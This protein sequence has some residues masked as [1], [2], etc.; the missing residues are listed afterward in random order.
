M[1]SRSNSLITRFSP[2][3]RASRSNQ[4]VQSPV[5]LLWC[6]LTCPLT[7]ATGDPT[8][9][10]VHYQCF[11]SVGTG[12]GPPSVVLLGPL[13][14]LCS[15]VSGGICSNSTFGCKSAPFDSILA[16]VSSNCTVQT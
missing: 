2:H 14:A 9:R 10:S 12:A 1:H 13:L 4:R 15:Q 6:S 11:C 3:I 5:E 7:V 16:D 8:P